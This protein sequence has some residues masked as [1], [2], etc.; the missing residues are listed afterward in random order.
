T[1]YMVL[2]A[3]YTLFLAK[4]TNQ[5]DMIVG[6]PVAGRRHADLE[7]IIGMFV[8]TL[9]MRNFLPGEKSFSDYLVE[10]KENTLKAFENQDYPYED[11]VERLVTGRDTSRNP[12]FDTM[13][14][15]QNAHIQ[16][17][18]IPG[19]HLTP[20]EYGHKTAKFDLTLSAVEEE[21]R[22]LLTFEYCTQLFKAET[23]DRFITY[24]K[25]IVDQVSADK[26]RKLSNFEIITAEEKRRLLFELNDSAGAYPKDKTI[27]QLFVEQVART[28][29]R[30][31]LVGADSQICP[32]V[33]PVGHVRQ[34]SLSYRHLNE[35]SDHA[36]GLLIEKGVRADSIVAIMMERSIELII[37]IL[38]I[39]KA[40]GAY[41][42]ID[43]EYPQERIDYMLKDS[44]ARILINKSEIRISKFET[45]PND[46]IINDQNKNFGIPFVLNLDYLNFEFVSNFVL[47]ASDLNPSNLNPSNLA[48][49]IY[50]SGSTG[51]PKGVMIDQRSLVNY[52]SWAAKTYVRNEEVNFPL[53][54]S[55]AFD[56]TVTS[57]FTPL[58]TGRAITI[59]N[60]NNK[61]NDVRL[62]IEEVLEDK[63]NGVIKLTP[64]HLKIIIDSSFSVRGIK[65][66]IVGGEALDMQL[67]GE[68]YERFN[69]AVEIYNEYGPT[70]ATVGCMI[71]KFN[72]AD[73][74]KTVPIGLPADNVQVYILD[75]YYRPLPVGVPGEL[76]ISG[77]GITR[78]YLNN[79]ELTAEKINKSFA[80]V[81][82]GLFQ[83]PPLVFYK[84]GDLAVWLPG[85]N[86]E[87]CGR[88]DQ[89][90]KIRGLSN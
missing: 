37:G 20:H 52:I 5:E 55:I 16:A 30:I 57:I 88:N 77:D 90:V 70:E 41:L 62:L 14:V 17:L 34:V 31:S 65:R 44:A 75:R 40:G 50:T 56:L 7:K 38:G 76:Y 66:F 89:Q 69:G 47:R 59:Y 26:Y 18:E 4:V 35:Q 2:L 10:V 46:Q 39:L 12:L 84:T 48:Y 82:G 54:T 21:G 22:L 53:Y 73:K 63:R 67:A 68:I 72:P 27:Q 11:L 60:N 6:S 61:N 78:G 19:L 24:F 25:N 71:Y 58:I 13:F 80:G 79:P 36:A 29:H 33:R 49:L 42:P 8:N 81:Q 87:F 83:K 3:T 23:I 45:N 15:L 64:A 51:K 86:I 74:R 28:P 9:A 43:P 32:S 1:L 85:G